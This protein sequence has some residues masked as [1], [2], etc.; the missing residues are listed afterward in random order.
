[1]IAFLSLLGNVAIAQTT[2]VNC[3]LQPA[4]AERLSSV[5]VAIAGLDPLVSKPTEGNIKLHT[6]TSDCCSMWQSPTGEFTFSAGPYDPVSQRLY[7]WG[8]HQNGWIEVDNTSSGAWVFGES[9]TIEPSLYSHSDDIEDVT[10]IKRSATLETQFYSGFT[11]PHWLTGSQSY[12]VYEVRGAEMLRIFELE[13]RV[14]SYIGDDPTTGLAAFGPLE[15]SW[16]SNPEL[17]VWYDG[18]EI[19]IP[20]A[21]FSR[22]LKWC[23]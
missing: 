5:P 15:E 13:N 17:L 12:R 18:I 19:V 9:S 11:A 20:D 6:A 1:M 16:M 10:G 14:L 8:Y 21:D 23:H 7:L 2:L 22:P 4:Q 3:I